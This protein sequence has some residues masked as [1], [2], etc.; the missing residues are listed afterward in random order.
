MENAFARGTGDVCML[1]ERWRYEISRCLIC[2]LSRSDGN[3]TYIMTCVP[4][5]KLQNHVFSHVKHMCSGH[6][7]QMHVKFHISHRSLYIICVS[8]SCH[9]VRY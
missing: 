2:S 4:R 1:Q 7:Y 5:V 9:Y 8:A 3:I 6:V